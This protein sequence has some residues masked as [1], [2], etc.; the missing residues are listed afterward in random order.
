MV[1]VLFGGMYHPNP[2]YSAASMREVKCTRL[3]YKTW[4]SKLHILDSH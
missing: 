1:M 2:P 3:G 4:L